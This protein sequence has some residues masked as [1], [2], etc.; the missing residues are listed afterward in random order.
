MRQFSSYLPITDSVPPCAIHTLRPCGF[1]SRLRCH[2]GAALRAFFLI[3]QATGIPLSGGSRS[4]T[5]G[6]ISFEASFCRCSEQPYASGRRYL[7]GSRGAYRR[8]EVHPFRASGLNSAAPNKVHPFRANGLNSAMK[9]G[10]KF[11]T[12]AGSVYACLH[13]GYGRGGGGCGGEG[14]LGGGGTHLLLALVI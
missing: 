8:N 14:E 10:P 2:K 7:S 3:H 12:T 13:Q 11:R 1:Y 6:G 9:I 5:V 4:S